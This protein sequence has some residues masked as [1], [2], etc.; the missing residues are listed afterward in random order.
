MSFGFMDIP[1]GGY[2]WTIEARPATGEEAAPAQAE[3][4]ATA[5][6]V[7]A[8][9]VRDQISR[10]IMNDG[11]KPDGP[12]KPFGD[13]IAD[14]FDA[15]GGGD[16]FVIGNTHI[17]YVRNNGMDGDDWSLNNV[18]TG[19]A[20]AIGWRVP[21]DADLVKQLRQIGE[22]VRKS[23]RFAVAFRRTA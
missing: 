4:D 3:R 16:R 8:Q 22:V 9:S 13:V 7:G 10:D 12:T 2:G 17:W 11:E 14:T 21:Y 18:Q 1:D 15:H 5:Q 23:L 20:G 6:Q 19:G